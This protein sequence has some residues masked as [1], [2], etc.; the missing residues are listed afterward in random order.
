MSELI[1]VRIEEIRLR[2]FRAFENARLALSD[3]TFLVGRNGAGKSSLLDAVDLLR[4]AASESLENALDGRGGLRKVQRARSGRGRKPPMGLAIVLSMLLPGDRTVRVLYGFEL[5]GD[6][7]EGGS[8]IRERLHCTGGTSFERRG[9]EFISNRKADVSPPVGNLVLPLVARA[10]SIWASVLETIRKLRAYELS[11]AHMAAA[12]KIGESVHLARDGANAGDVLKTVQRTDIHR[13]IVERLKLVT[14]GLVDVRAE[15]LMGRR[16]LQFV[17]RQGETETKFDASQV[18]Q[19][20]LRSLGVLLALRQIPPPAM[21]LL[22]EIENSLH[23]GALSVILEAALASSEGTRVVIATH[24][25]EVLSHPSVVGERVRIIE[26]RDG[27]SQIFRLSAETEAAVGSIDTVGW[28]LRSNALWPAE[29]PERFAGDVL[30][31]P[32]NSE[33]A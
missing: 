26:W 16:V 32:G 24:S 8:N 12:P 3:L 31:P 21:V 28:M 20:T 19:G 17:Q 10:D 2:N 4:Q 25:P 11:P 29:E 14:D 33:Q 30:D 13:W 23:P 27:T 9:T 1:R 22:D 5:Y 6:P 7:K 18:S 15:A